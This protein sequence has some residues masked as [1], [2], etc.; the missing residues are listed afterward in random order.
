MLGELDVA[1]VIHR[2]R[3]L[4]GVVDFDVHPVS[5]SDPRQQATAAERKRSRVA[6]EN[7]RTVASNSAVSGIT[8]RRVP[9]RRYPTVITAGSKTS[10]RLVTIV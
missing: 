1:V 2:G 10:M 9:A 7:V 3:V 8:L 6:R 5:G 4:V